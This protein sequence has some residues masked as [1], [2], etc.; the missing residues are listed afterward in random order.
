MINHKSSFYIFAFNEIAGNNM[1]SIR[2]FVEEQ[3][4]YLYLSYYI[5]I[6]EY[7]H[8]YRSSTIQ[9]YICMP[10]SAWYLRFYHFM[11]LKTKCP[12]PPAAIY[13]YTTEIVRE[14]NCI[15]TYQPLAEDIG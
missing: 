3:Y 8:L 9:T 6:Y 2:I 7:I 1:W 13:A 12:F 14:Q 10:A 5:D 11:H 15:P 4:I